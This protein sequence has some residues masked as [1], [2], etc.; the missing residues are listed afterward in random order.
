MIDSGRAKENRYDA[1]NRLPQLVDT[2]ISTANRRQRRGRAGRV[3]PGEAYYMYT[4]ERSHAMAPFQPA[5]MLRVPLHELCLQ[6]KL[7]DLG[8]IELFLA[9]ALEPPSA[10]AVREAVQTLSEVRQTRPP[11]WRPKHAH[12]PSVAI[13]LTRPPS[14]LGHVVRC[15]HS[16]GFTRSSL[17]SAITWRR[18]LSMCA[19]KG[20]QPNPRPTDLAS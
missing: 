19:C 4:R 10:D 7:L 18:Y 13:A 12:S 9:K 2:W 5:E 17:R 8:P 3:Q 6:I 16:K 20:T 15:K 14:A 1:L 11:S